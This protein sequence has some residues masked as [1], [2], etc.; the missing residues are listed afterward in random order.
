VGVAT[1]KVRESTME[2]TVYVP[3][4]PEGEEMPF[5]IIVGPLVTHP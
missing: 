4:I 3:L 5:I 2:A 1:V